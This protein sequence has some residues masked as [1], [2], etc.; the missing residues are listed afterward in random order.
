MSQYR[1]LVDA[2]K[3]HIK[4][5]RIALLVIILICIALWYGWSK[6]PESLTIH[7]PPDLRSGSTR[8]WWDIPPENVYAFSYY[9]FGQLNRWPTNGEEDMPRNLHRLQHFLTPSCR[10]T[11][12][13]EMKSR[14]LAGEMRN[15]VRGVYEIPGRGYPDDPTFRV[16][17]LD[18][19]T[20]RVMLD[21]SADEY[22]MAEPVKRALA[23]YPIK[24]IRYDIDP[25]LNPWGLAFDCY[26]GKPQLLEIE[27]K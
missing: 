11:L 16:K 14:R 5:L 19:N 12:D 9:I 27:E 13:S 1:F 15:R 25:E 4:T 2:Q 18:N 17:Q 24:I 6:S 26:T 20:W 7:V 21:I 10:E 22:F 8:L 23:R 3:A